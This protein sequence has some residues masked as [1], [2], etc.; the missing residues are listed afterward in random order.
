MK[1]ETAVVLANYVM[2]A[3]FYEAVIGVVALHVI[4]AYYG[5]RW[6]RARA[7]AKGAHDADRAT[8]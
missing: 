8:G 4:A 1:M 5:V 2:L 3:L 6:A 7:A